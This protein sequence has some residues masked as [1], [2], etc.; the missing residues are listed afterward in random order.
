MKQFDRESIVLGTVLRY[1]NRA[2]Q[3]V[4][5]YLESDKF[6]FDIDGSFGISHNIIWE[7]ITELFSTKQSPSYAT[8]VERLPDY[9]QYLNSLVMRLGDQYH[10]HELDESLLLDLANKVDIGGIVY[11]VASRGLKYSELLQDPDLFSSTVA[12]IKDIDKW[13]ADNIEVFQ[14]TSWQKSGY[15]QVGEIVDLLKDKWELQKQG[16]NVSLLP[17]GIPTLMANKLFPRGKLAVVHGLSGSG[18]SSFC[19]QYALGVA[20]SLVAKGLPGCVAIN[21][22]EMTQEELVESLVS[23]LARVDTSKLL[24]NSLTDIEYQRL[25]LWAE[26][27]S[28]LPIYVDDTNFLTTTAMQYRSGGLHVSKGPVVLMVSDYG[29]LFADDDSSEEQRISHIFRAQFRLSR[30]LNTTVLAIS[31]ST[32]DKNNMS[33]IAGADGTRQSRGVLQAADIL[34]EIYNPPA[35]KASGRQIVVPSDKNEELAYVMIQKFRGAKTGEAVPFGW[36]PELT[37]FWDTTLNQIPGNEIFF[38]NIEDMLI[39]L[40][41]NPTDYG[42]VTW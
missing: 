6:V 36:Y 22:L 3:V 12:S 33:K 27:I 24:D 10:L 42:F 2:A 15:T 8:V 41:L 17:C 28:R 1:G 37:S 7:T 40:G 38:T 4:L 16:Q 23:T 20:M 35:I 34:I 26:V 11:T 29:E 18:K 30:L 31:Q 39:A 13:N 14:V 19:F 32:Q 21:S 9:T 5:P 25:F